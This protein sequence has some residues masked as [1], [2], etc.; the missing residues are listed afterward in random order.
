MNRPTL[1]VADIIRQA[2]NSF[3][4][5]NRDHL[6]W[7]HLKVL[8]AIRD[9]R[10]AA[11]GGHIDRCARCGYQ[12]ISYNSCRNRHCPKCQTRARE[13]WVVKQTAD[14]LPV[15]Y[16]HVVFTL[17]HELSAVGLQNKRVVYNLLFH[18]AAQTLLEVAANPK[19]LGAEIGFLA[20]LHTWGQ[21][22][23]HH[24]HIHC[25]IPAGG[26]TPDH[27]RWIRSAPG[28]FLPV[29]VLSAVF[30]GKF[31]DGLKRLFRQ[32]KL[33]FHGPLNSLR[34]PKRFGAFLRQLWCKQWV[35]YARKPFRS[36]EYVL[37]YLGRYT[38]RV[39]ISNHRLVA[40]EDGKVTFRWRDYAHSNKKRMMTLTS[41]EFLR[42][43]LLHVLPRGLTRIRHFGLLANRRRRES[44]LLCRR[45]LEQSPPS[46]SP[47]S[48]ADHHVWTCPRCA[49]PM[50]IIQKLTTA[51][52]LVTG[53]RSVVSFA[54]TS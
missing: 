35:V 40:F 21:N 5:R 4:E 15:P 18:A 10:T 7:P 33:S 1:E 23:Q 46:S 44:M 49:G 20:V 38:H 45:L 13:N 41:D 14:L 34:E 8:R 6:G 36:P 17:P 26:L 22:L 31:S 47:S 39:A 53:C 16:F 2:G 29:R 51:Q 48:E 12:A 52:F 54:D 28:F 37:Q 24:P 30:R 11:L 9:C 50:V 19:H 42:R 32:G 43:F 25:I 27:S 3:I